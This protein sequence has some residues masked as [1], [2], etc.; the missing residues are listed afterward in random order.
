MIVP[1]T[2]L[3]PAAVADHYDELDLFYREIWGEHV[4]HGLWRT[5]RDSPEQAVEQ[6]ALYTAAQAQIRAGDRVCDVGAG[7]GATARLL[8]QRLGAQVTAVT[9]T[10]TQYE[11]ACA[12]R[13]VSGQPEPQYLLQD[14]LHND[15]PAQSFA[16]LIAIESTE[17]MDDKLHCFAE[18][19]RVL[20]PGGRVA[21]CAWLARDKPRPW[22]IRWLLE[23]ICR[24]GRL[25]G[26][27]SAQEYH[28]LLLRAGFTLEAYEDL[29]AQV[30]RTWPIC[31]GRALRRIIREPR[32]R[33]YM[34]NRR[35]R[36]RIFL[37]TAVRIWLA[38]RTGAMRY[39]L[40]TAQRA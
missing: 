26:M 18:M 15:L 1:R 40:F 12:Q 29:S 37:L 21:I 23:P 24:E 6:L 3:M 36:N 8:A 22:H 17:H 14:W 31:V 32:Y 39:G 38:Y 5:K 7:Y 35:Q 33:A 28:D 9:I 30:W 10:P 16:A 34:L 4:H 2:P 27:G 25:P 11:Y 19:F 20:R 13:V